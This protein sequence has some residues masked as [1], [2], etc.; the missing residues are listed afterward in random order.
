MS[1]EEIGIGMLVGMEFGERLN[2]RHRAEAIERLR[3]ELAEAG[4][5]EMSQTA[6]KLA[7]RA[8]VNRLID[9]LA[10]EEQGQR[11]NKRHSVVDNGPARVEDY[12]DT[13]DDNLRRMSGG[14]LSFDERSQDQTKQR[15]PD[16]RQATNTFMDPVPA[17]ARPRRM[18]R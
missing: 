3:Q 4:I 10:A 5:K 17:P 14:A 15:A 2:E 11:F 12:I 7:A 8:C 6:L 13:A 16:V 1:M 18:R 9:E